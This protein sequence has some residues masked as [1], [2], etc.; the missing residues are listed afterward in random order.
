MLGKLFCL[1]GWHCDHPTRA[2]M[3]YLTRPGLLCSLKRRKYQQ[4]EC[5]RC[6]K[7]VWKPYH[8]PRI[9]EPYSGDL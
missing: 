1:I 7:S 3:Q 9:F 8:E 5:C 6:R 4:V 2:A